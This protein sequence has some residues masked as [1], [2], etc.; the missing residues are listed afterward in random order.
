M[1]HSIE[2]KGSHRRTTIGFMKLDMCEYSLDLKI[3]RS[4]YRYH[5]IIKQIYQD[6]LTILKQHYKVIDIGYNVKKVNTLQHSRVL[7]RRKRCP[8]KK[9]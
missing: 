1:R 4:C 7:M 9:K 5:P 2:Y 8:T 6:I 3:I